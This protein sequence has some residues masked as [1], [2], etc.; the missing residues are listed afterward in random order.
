MRHGR[1]VLA[2][3][4]ADGTAMRATTIRQ[5]LFRAWIALSAAWSL[6]WFGYALFVAQEWAEGHAHPMGCSVGFFFCWF[7]FWSGRFEGMA[8][9]WVLTAA[10]L[11][12]RWVIRGFR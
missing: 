8:V 5:G 6:F 11:C 12:A 2:G 1:A 3:G 4:G 9:P 10:A 7:A